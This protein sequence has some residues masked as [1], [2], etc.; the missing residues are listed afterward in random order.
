MP[1]EE[2]P[3][4]YEVGYGKPPKHTRFQPGRSGNPKGRPKRTKDAETLIERELE[5][6]IRIKEGGASRTLTMRE[7][8]IKSLVTA[9]IKGEKDARK[10]VFTFVMNQQDVEGLTVDAADQQA[11]DAF[12][13]RLNRM[14][15]E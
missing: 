8:F 11:L 15:E 2:E 10:L 13:A 12:L 6:P 7:A 9:A 5:R 3:K 4:D 14:E 1:P